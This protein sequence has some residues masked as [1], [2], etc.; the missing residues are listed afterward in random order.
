MVGEMIKIC[1]WCDKKFIPE[2]YEPRRECCSDECQGK[3]DN[4]LA[5]DKAER[6]NDKHTNDLFKYPIY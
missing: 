3:Y 2:E 4:S 6:P 5:N 1:S